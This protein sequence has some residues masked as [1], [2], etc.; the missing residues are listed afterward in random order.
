MGGKV[1]SYKKLQILSP[2]W[3]IAL[4]LD[5]LFFYG[6]GPRRAGR[7]LPSLEKFPAFCA[8]LLSTEKCKSAT[9]RDYLPNI[10]SD[11]CLSGFT[12]CNLD[13]TFLNEKKLQK[14]AVR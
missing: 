2:E 4:G 9:N 3:K 5:S 8:T 10:L 12:E 7:P 13:F 14:V 1:N 6:A 11:C